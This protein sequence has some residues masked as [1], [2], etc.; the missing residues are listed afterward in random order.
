MK[1]IQSL[2]WTCALGNFMGCFFYGLSVF[3]HSVDEEADDTGWVV[4]TIYDGEPLIRQ[5][6][7]V[8]YMVSLYWAF[9]TLSTVGYGDVLPVTWQEMAFCSFSQVLGATMYAFLTG[10]IVNGVNSFDRE[11][12]QV[13]EYVRNLER[14]TKERKLPKKLR[15]AVGVAE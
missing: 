1:I 8:Q 4:Q 5:P 2:F 12:T 11:K 3:E 6:I 13:R 9:T 14:Y 7:G 15:E 10:Y